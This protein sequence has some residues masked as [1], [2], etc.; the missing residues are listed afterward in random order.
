MG[1]RI[2]LNAIQCGTCKSVVRSV[3]VHDFVQ[4]DCGKVAV[5]GGTD[6]LRRL[7]EPRDYVNLSIVIDSH[8]RED[9]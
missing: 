7:G 6:Y 3:H 1:E 2:L 4:C 8:S 5:D 9:N